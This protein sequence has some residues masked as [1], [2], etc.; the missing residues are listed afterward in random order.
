M[1]QALFCVGVGGLAGFQE[2]EGF[3][4]FSLSMARAAC[5]ETSV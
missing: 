2:E 3:S 4:H 5:S 1:T